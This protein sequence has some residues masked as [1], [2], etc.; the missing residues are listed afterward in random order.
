LKVVCHVTVLAIAG[1]Q[2]DPGKR[3]MRA[4]RQ[5][6]SYPCQT[7]APSIL[8]DAHSVSVTEGARHE[9]S[10]SPSLSRQ[11]GQSEVGHG[12]LVNLLTNPLEPGCGADLPVAALPPGNDREELGGERFDR[13]R[14]TAIRALKLGDEADDGCRSRSDL[15]EAWRGEYGRC[16]GDLSDSAGVEREEK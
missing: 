11:I 6:T 13:E 15:H 4:K 2:R 5:V 1:V 7:D 8:T 10:M 14:R 9:R 16:V 3:Q 12:G